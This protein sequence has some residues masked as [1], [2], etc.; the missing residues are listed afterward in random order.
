MY[1]SQKK[2]GQENKIFLDN[3][4]MN[5]KNTIMRYYTKYNEIYVIL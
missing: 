4:T 1:G 5:E 2:N 3:T